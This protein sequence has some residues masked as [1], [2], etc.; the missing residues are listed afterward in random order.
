MT[1]AESQRALSALAH[2]CDD[3]ELAKPLLKRLLRKTNPTAL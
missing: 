1:F 3:P 2:L